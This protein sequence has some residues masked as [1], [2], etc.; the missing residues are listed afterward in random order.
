MTTIRDETSSLIARRLR[1]EREARGWSQADLAARSGVSKA[2]VSK[3]EREEM[4]PTAV[5]LVKLA[6]AFDLTLAGLLLRAEGDGGRLVRAADQPSWRDPDT[7]YVR[8]QVFARPDHPLELAAIELPPRKHVTLP[9]ASYAHIRQVVWVRE[10]RLV[11]T[12]GGT[13]NEL[14]PGDCLGFGS[15]TDVTLAND[16]DAPCTYVVVLARG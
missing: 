8:R 16:T 12:E 6:S 15:P 7:G 2:T 3:I 9:A 5:V 10:G 14:G 4:S 1:V 11:V 13:R